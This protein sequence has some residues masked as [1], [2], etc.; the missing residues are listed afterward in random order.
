MH[1]ELQNSCK[2]LCCINKTAALSSYIYEIKMLSFVSHNTK[3]LPAESC[4]HV[5]S[6]KHGKDTAPS[7]DKECTYNES[8]YMKSS[9]AS[10]QVP[11]LLAYSIKYRLLTAPQSVTSMHNTQQE[12]TWSRKGKK[13]IKRSQHWGT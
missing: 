2:K 7:S 5:L 8:P 13:L 9:T 4:S 10:D 11:E 3:T 12:G 1:Q 6:M